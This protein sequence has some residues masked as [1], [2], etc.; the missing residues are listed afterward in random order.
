M[1][2]YRRNIYVL[3]FT[4]FIAALSWTQIV[5]FLPLYLR[6]LGVAEE[7]LI[8]WSS[9]IFFA[10]CL[11]SIVC[12]PMWGKIG[13]RYGRKMM[14]MRAGLCLCA[15][16]F[17]MSY[18]QTPWQLAA[19]RFLNGALTGFIPG[20]TSII[21][22]NT[23]RAMVSRY[24]ATAQTCSA[25]GQIIG[26]AV[27]GFLAAWFGYRASMK[28]SALA[29]FV[30]VL[31]VLALVQERNKSQ[32]D[33]P[34]SL[35]A[36][37]RTS[38]R[39]PLLAAM[40]VANAM[41]GFFVLAMTVVLPLYLVSLGVDARGQGV[42]VGLVLAIP[43]AAMFTTAH[44][45]ASYAVRRTHERAIIV[46][47]IGAGAGV[48]ILLFAH[49]VWVLAILYFL[50]SVF[51]SAVYSA[52]A[53]LI[54]TRVEESFRGRAFGMQASSATFGGLIATMASGPVGKALGLPAVF[55]MVTIVSVLCVLAFR[56]L[57][58]KPQTAALS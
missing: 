39:S 18:C 28:V 30:S 27:G 34:T 13:D 43:A 21:A 5:P 53:S 11:A 40:M 29:V 45:W 58:S 51:L 19:L 14:T 15:I 47:M 1:H 10:Q 36:D 33:K 35:L 17:G 56:G 54:A 9:R 22:T 3:S 57:A 50:T 46:G 12:M 38:L 42:L 23:P 2:F 7:N 37:F 41:T 52:S 24:V 25:A 55:V 48:S 49:S 32:I 44:P 26:P 31:L 16:Y 4:I 8:G 6:E 20:S